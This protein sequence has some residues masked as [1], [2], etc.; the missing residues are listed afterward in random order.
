MQKKTLKFIDLFAGVG[1]FH[2]AISKLGHTCVFACD[3]DEHC[4]KIYKSNYKIDVFGDLTKID[5]NKIPKH[6]ILCAGFPCQPFSN[7]GKKKGFDDDRGTLFF[8]IEKIL[9]KHK[10]NYIILE[11]VK[12][13]VRHNDGK[14]W[15][16][17][18]KKLKKLGYMFP[19]EEIIMSPHQ[20]GIPQNRQ[21]VFLLGRLD[22]KPIIQ[23]PKDKRSVSVFDIVDR[24]LVTKDEDIKMN[25]HEN[26][27]I[28][29][30]DEF[31]NKAGDDVVGF[32][33]WLEEF[34][35][36]YSTLNLPK[37]KQDYVRKNRLFYKKHKNWIDRWMKTHDV[38]SFSNKRDRRFE[39]QAGRNYNSIYD[40]IVQFRQS[41]IRC[42]KPDFFPTL[43]AMVQIPLIPKLGRRL[44]P[45]EVARLQ[46]FPAKFKLSDNN[47]QSYKQFGNSVNVDVV[48]YLA[49]Q[50]ID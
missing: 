45:L 7:A 35:K 42:K 22:V 41:G 17:L 12:H 9:K 13:L 38:F 48:H 44:T 27:L 40:V 47:R 26:F 46:S 6:D 19:D 28:K 34:G 32:P 1:G 49:K 37:W 10:P 21:R 8:Y 14:T 2:Q 15:D 30:W 4:Q 3:I 5:V 18:N 25:N 24:N 31:K 33:I 23:I 11:N 50:L 20:L 16:L 36:R 29:I 43:V 39:W